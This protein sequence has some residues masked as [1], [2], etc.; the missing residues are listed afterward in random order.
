MYC[1]PQLERFGSFRELTRQGQTCP[2]ADKL[3]G[4]GDIL[5]LAGPI[6]TGCQG[7]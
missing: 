5:V 3:Q 7:S 6:P 2:T 1:K 4:A